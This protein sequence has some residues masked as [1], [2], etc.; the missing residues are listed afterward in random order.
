MVG[1]REMRA[2]ECCFGEAWLQQLYAWKTVW[3]KREYFK[4][5]TNELD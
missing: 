3:V 2:F 1:S 4:T 5:F